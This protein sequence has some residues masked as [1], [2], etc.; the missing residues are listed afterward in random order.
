[1]RT[2]IAA[3]VIIL[4]IF[5][6]LWRGGEARR[7]IDGDGSGYYA[8]LTA[9]FIHHTTDFTAVY[10]V[11][12]ERRGLDYMAHYFHKT[13]KGMINKYYLGT[14]LL[15]LP[16]FLLAW[17]YS[18]IT[19]MPAD[20]YN[21]LFQYS[22]SLA[23]AVYLAV[24]LLALK[25]ILDLK[26][27]SKPI[28]LAVLIVL[29][30]GTNLFYYAFLHP[31]HSHVYSFAAIAVFLL[32]TTLFFRTGGNKYLMLAAMMLGVIVLIRPTNILIML[33]IPFVAAESEVFQQRIKQLLQSKVVLLFFIL[34]FLSVFMLQPVFNFIQLGE[35]SLWSYRNEGFIF[36]KPALLSFLFSYRK[37]FF[38]YTPLML[39]I[40]PA[41]VTLWQRSLYQFITFLAYFLSLVFMLS[42]WWNWFFG[43]SFGMRAMIDH[44]PVLVLPIAELIRQL[45]GKRVTTAIIS[46]FLGGVIILNLVQ[47][48]QY[49][50]GI[51]HPDSMSKEK[52]WFV[53]F[54][55]SDQYR[56]VF[57]SYPEA[58]F[59]PVKEESGR[60]F[61]NEMEGQSAYWTSN[62]VVKS[63]MAYSGSYVAELNQSNIYSP[64]L[65][66]TG[67]SLVPKNEELY[68]SISLMYKELSVQASA[69]ALLVYAASDL[70]ND[71]V[72]Y[73]TFKMK[74]I[75]DTI[76]D[77]W[78]NAIFG[79]KVPAWDNEI[80]QVKIYI[81][82]RQQ[83]LFQIDDFDVNIYPVNR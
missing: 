23:A 12:K 6:Q 74:Q 51:L 25:R 62:G 30:F 46:I 14:A 48:Y 28:Q 64:T 7:T 44:Y 8:Y 76:T 1:M 70:Q 19:G 37:G 57:G 56:H 22:V 3:G 20:G 49:Y 72:F 21:I 9:V 33:S 13:E 45:S 71:L 58:V 42:S 29:L 78:R 80:R 82:N 61:L 40:V 65:V 5:I 26:G 2:F 69:E 47:T 66:L 77:Q 60:T 50:A 73:K 55:T 15:M 39:L 81:W 10:E 32:F 59:G 41:M 35:I 27:F 83:G 16:F 36:Q 52:Y 11:E 67:E 43:D 68:V 34:V 54:K 4:F 53:F 38:V 79:F 63:A 18:V 75:P 17:L 31:S 24:G